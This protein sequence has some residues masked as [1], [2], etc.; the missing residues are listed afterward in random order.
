M[1]H[2]PPDVRGGVAA[3]DAVMTFSAINLELAAAHRADI[4]REWR[5]RRHLA[6]AAA[7]PPRHRERR[8]FFGGRRRRVVPAPR[9]LG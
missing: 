3:Q 5:E 7:A 6:A 2:H 4:D 8:S 1:S 9:P